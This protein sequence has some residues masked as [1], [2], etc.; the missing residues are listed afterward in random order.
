MKVK[1]IAR[2]EKLS[3]EEFQHEFAIQNQPVIIS[4][5]AKD[6]PA[7]SLWSPE[8]FKTMFGNVLAPLRGSDN[9]IDVFFGEAS[10]KTVLSIAEY[11]DLIVAIPPDKRPPYLGNIS[12]NDPLA[13][14]HLDIIK[15]HIKFPNY[16]PVNRGNDLHLW[17][18]AEQ[19]KSTI[20]N[21][22]YHNFNAQIF[23]KKAFLLFPPDQHQL[24]YVKKIDN[25]LWSSPIDPQNPDLEKF[26]LFRE[27]SG[28]EGILNEGDIIFIPAFWWHQALAITTSINVNMWVF[29]DDVSEFY[30]VSKFWS[31]EYSDLSDTSITQ[32][33]RI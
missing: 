4:G 25:E 7:C 30:E 13:K 6:W 17:I 20:H 9:E 16:F 32:G 24:L 2:I 29:T 14:P 26:P 15:S 27:A 23:G 18:G 33:K 5:A 1:P 21:D 3:L 12:F 8:T 22:N 10:Q 28:L 19:Q 31:G 11:I